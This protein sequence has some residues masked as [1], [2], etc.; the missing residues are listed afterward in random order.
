VLFALA[1]RAICNGCPT[2]LPPQRARESP[3]AAIATVLQ[4]LLS[5]ILGY[6]YSHFTSRMDIVGKKH[7]RAGMEWSAVRSI[8]PFEERPG[9]LPE[10]HYF[11]RLTMPACL[12]PAIVDAGG[13]RPAG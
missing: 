8:K 2:S 4:P 7:A 3:A 13:R 12:K 1:H 6:V 5:P 9:G 10:K 11:A